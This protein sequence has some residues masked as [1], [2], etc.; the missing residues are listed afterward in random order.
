MGPPYKQCEVKNHIWSVG[1][2]NRGKRARGVNLLR[3]FWKNF[4]KEDFGF[5]IFEKG[6]ILKAFSGLA[7]KHSIKN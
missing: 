6:A 3:N 4:R 1:Y 2:Q 5:E 7:E